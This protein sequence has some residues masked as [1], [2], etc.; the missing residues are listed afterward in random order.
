MNENMSVRGC[1]ELRQVRDGQIINTVYNPNTVLT[2]GK[3]E[4]ARGMVADLTP[5]SRVDWMSIGIGSATIT[6][7]DT[8]LGSEYLKYGL[9]NITGSTMT[10]TTANDTA[11]WV[12]SFGIDASKTVNEAGLFNASG[13]NTGSMYARTCFA[14]IVAI[15]GD[16]IITDWRVAFA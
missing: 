2:I 9:G 15:S 5:G 14:N 4:I 3:S 13:L 8:T 7:A 12:G 16:T 6:A 10:T 1:V 11:Y